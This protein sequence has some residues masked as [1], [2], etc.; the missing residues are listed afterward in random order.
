LLTLH[1]NQIGSLAAQ[2]LNSDEDSTVGQVIATFPNSFYVKTRDDQLLFITN[3]SLRSPITVNVAYFGSFTDIVKPLELV[4]LHDGRLCNSNLSIDFANIPGREEKVLVDKHPYYL[5]LMEASI[6]LSTILN[7]I[8][9][10]GSVLDQ[11]QL[12]VH[13]SIGGFV[14]HGL[15]PLRNKEIP[16]EFAA[17]A[18]K[19]IGLGPGF[20]PSG[21]DFLLGFLLIYNSLSPAIARTPIYLEFKQLTRRT[22]WISAKLVDYAQHL[23]VDDQLLR[24]IRSMSDVHGDTVTALE[25]L[26]P[27]GHTSGIDIATGAVLA[28]SVVCDIALEQRTTEAIA[29]KLGFL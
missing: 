7:V 12:M 18:S 14:R 16:S 9:N 28:L 10:T 17:A 26:I 22:N 13:V 11:N 20:T 15:L 8:E 6:L 1:A 24:V 27:R 21:D 4:Y 19:I 3:R 23:Q 5:K 2:A 29:A 25:A